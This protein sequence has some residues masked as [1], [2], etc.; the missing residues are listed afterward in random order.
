[1]AL[2]DKGAQHDKLVVDKYHNPNADYQMTTFDYVLRP[3]ADAISGAIVIYL[4]RVAEAKGRFY[5]IIAR[6]ADVANT[7]TI[8]DYGAV[9]GDSEC[10]I[11]NIILNG[12]CD[13]CLL[14][15]DG[16]AWHPLGGGAGRWPGLLTTAA[17]G[18]T[19]PPTSLAPTTVPATTLTT[20]AP[21]TLA[22]TT[23]APT[24]LAPTTLA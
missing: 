11:A 2:E 18:T 5:S 20:A 7:I 1:M 13:R 22:P 15:S 8:S 19:Q 3:E 21:T 23:L 24:T 10:W 17:P 9:T 6:N 12:A 16:L 4:P 14:Y